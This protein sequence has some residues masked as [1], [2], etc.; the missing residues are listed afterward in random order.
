MASPTVSLENSDLLPFCIVV[1]DSGDGKPAPE[2]AAHPSASD[3]KVGIRLRI[4]PTL[5]ASL[6]LNCVKKGRTVEGVDRVK[7]MSIKR[8]VMNSRGRGDNQRSA[9]IRERELFILIGVLPTSLGQGQFTPS[10][11][12][13]VME[14]C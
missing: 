3:R 7:S 13:E 6:R 5:V 11:N 14:I 12:N 1:D 10:Q 8:Q 2:A 9:G 4:S